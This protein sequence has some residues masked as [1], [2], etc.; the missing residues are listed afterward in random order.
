M[1]VPRI[2]VV[3]L[4]IGATVAPGQARAAEP[5]PGAHWFETY[6]TSADGTKLHA[7]VFRPAG[8]TDGDK[9]PVILDDSIY[10]GSG[11][12]FPGGNIPLHKGPNLKEIA[13]LINVGHPFQRG[14]T[15]VQVTPRGWGA[16]GGCDD[17]F[18]P[19]T[20]LDAKA[21]VEWAADQPWS[22]G[23]VG[24]WGMSN[25]AIDEIEALAAKP[26]GL[27]AIVPESPMFDA[28]KAFFMNGNRYPA[29]SI[30]FGYAPAGLL[31]PPSLRADP[32]EQ[33]AMADRATHPN[34]VVGDAVGLA[35]DDP[36]SAFWRA[37]N[38]EPAIIGSQVPVMLS[39]GFLDESV[40]VG[41][42]LEAWSSLSGPKRAWLGEFDHVP[43]FDATSI[44][45]SGFVD[46]AMRFFDVYLKGQGVETD[47]AIE[48]ETGPDGWW[49]SEASW[50]PADATMYSLRVL[51]GRYLDEP[52]N[53]A[54]A[55][56]W[57]P[58][59][60][61]PITE[62]TGAGSWT[63]T[64][65]LPYDLHLAGSPVLDVDVTAAVPH[66]NLVALLY[67]VSADGRA[68]IVSR[69]ASVQ[70]SSG[71]VHLELYPQDWLFHT[72]HR[73][74]IL[75]SGSDD[76]WFSPGITGTGVTVSAGTLA[77]PFLALRRVANLAGGPAQAL[78]DQDP[79]GVDP[80]TIS[81]RTA[82]SSLPPPPA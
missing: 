26:R 49:R 45:R 21:A 34:C 15:V 1:R 81:S 46:E 43:A 6:I 20:R 11:G 82:P 3:A 31:S 65:R 9:T 39:L 74:G 12:S 38:M 75:V 27:A 17:M 66:T 68:R 54:Q 80:T 42:F 5:V 55:H 19:A 32:H 47:P 2:L 30:F 40:R 23:K 69:G 63:F 77:M 4:A 72:G 52:G 37:R 8:L 25:P 59:G 13:S 24:M 51:A 73:I 67:D 10:S 70:A 50:P 62:R 44:G 79:I 14:Y 28:Y 36:S 48:V 71:H 35:G 7:D 78:Q 22:T 56:T 18:G 29:N 41:S 61:T 57:T 76:L 33:L 16:S 64:Q 60:A 53:T 58:F